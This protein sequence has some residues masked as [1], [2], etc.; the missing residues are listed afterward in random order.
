ATIHL[1][2]ATKGIIYQWKE[3]EG[4]SY[5]DKLSGAKTDAQGMYRISSI[6][7]QF[8]YKQG[9]SYLILTSKKEGYARTVLPKFKFAPAADAPQTAPTVRMGPSNSIAG[10]LFHDD[11]RPVVGAVVT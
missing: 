5:S 8:E 2:F 7:R 3:I 11:G 10:K 4:F 1:G 9:E 6:P